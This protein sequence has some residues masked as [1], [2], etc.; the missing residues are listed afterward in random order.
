VGCASEKSAKS[1]GVQFVTLVKIGAESVHDD[2][3]PASLADFQRIAA[4]H[5]PTVFR[6]AVE[7][8]LPLNIQS[9]NDVLD[10]LTDLIGDRVVPV[11]VLLPGDRGFIGSAAGSRKGPLRTTLT[12]KRLFREVAADLKKGAVDNG[13][14]LYVKALDILAVAPEL[15]SVVR[16]PFEVPNI[17][18][19]GQWK[20]WIGSGGH[21]AELH[22][23]PDDNLL[24]LLWGSKLVT[25]MPFDVMKDIYIGDFASG[26]YGVPSSLVDPGIPEL[27]RFPMFTRAMA[28][29]RTVALRPGDA[30]YIP[31]HWWHYIESYGLNVAINHWWKDV[32]WRSHAFAHVAFLKSLLAIRDLPAHWRSF[33]NVMFDNFVFQSNGDP[34]AHLPVEAQGIFGRQT[35]HRSAQIRELI[36]SNE[37]TLTAATYAIERLM[38]TVC[39]LSRSASLRFGNNEALLIRGLDG[40]NEQEIS[41]QC[42][43]MLVHFRTPQTPREV[44]DSSTKDVSNECVA[45]ER[46]CVIIR[47]LVMNRTLIPIAPECG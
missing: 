17:A 15:R 41:A 21:R 3:W 22:T 13:L 47:G 28:T 18:P 32:D 33:W 10:W 11:D 25:L 19:P 24:C 5:E 27:E 6:G 2:A 14:T 30:L 37:R 23:D 42:L 46:F 12:G 36:D 1:Q 39:A 35:P 43:E 29:A 38:S 45:W 16:L 20:A 4:R 9:D 40:G 26:P 34:Y 7:D 8:S 31:H 44:F